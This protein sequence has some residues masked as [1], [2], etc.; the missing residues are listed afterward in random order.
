MFHITKTASQD[1]EFHETEWTM[2]WLLLKLHDQ[3]SPNRILL[4]VNINTFYLLI[5]LIKFQSH[6]PWTM[7]WRNHHSNW[8]LKC[9]VRTKHTG[10]V[11]NLKRSLLVQQSLFSHTKANCHW[12]IWFRTWN[13]TWAGDNQYSL[14]KG[15]IL[16]CFIVIIFVWII[17]GNSNVN[18]HR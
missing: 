4:S 10:V 6:M 3:M 2:T 8:Y 11:W 9:N 18:K 17:I 15:S 16:S 13:I 5:I 14:F 7:I 12:N 1:L